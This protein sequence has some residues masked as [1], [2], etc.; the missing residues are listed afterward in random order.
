MA[1]VATMAAAISAA[2][3]NFSLVIQLLHLIG[4]AKAWLLY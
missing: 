4:K 2:D 3:R 1:G